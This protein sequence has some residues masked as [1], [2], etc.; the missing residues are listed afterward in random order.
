M[1][2]CNDIEWEKTRITA[3]VDGEK[4]VDMLIQITSV[5]DKIIKSGEQNCC[6]VC[7]AYL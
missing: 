3:L 4:F 5:K 2:F 6:S 1:E 7:R